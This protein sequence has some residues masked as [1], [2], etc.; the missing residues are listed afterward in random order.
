LQLKRTNDNFYLDENKRLYKNRIAKF[1]ERYEVLDDINL[2]IEKY[3]DCLYIDEIQDFAGHDFN[4]LKSI[5]KANCEILFVGD[6]YQHTFNTSRDGTVNKKLF[7][8]YDS[9]K[10]EFKKMD[11]EI[12]TKS[13]LKSR[14]CSITICDFITDNIGIDIEALDDRET[15]INIIDNQQDADDIIND[16]SIIKLFY[17]EHYKYNC[18]SENWGASKGMTYDDVCVVLNKDALQK[19]EKQNLKSLAPTTKNKFYV[20]CSRAKNNL[21]FVSDRFVRKVE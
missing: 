15:I 6:F 11:L 10:K 4:F 18:R 21:Y 5:T 9:Y 8:N 13:L 14:R 2:R 17:E 12:D 19:F 3:F 16:N 20:A 7:D 1:L